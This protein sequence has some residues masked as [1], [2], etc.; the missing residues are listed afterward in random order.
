MITR[1]EQ[2][3]KQLDLANLDEAGEN[4]SFAAKIDAV[5]LHRVF[6]DSSCVL[7]FT[8]LRKRSTGVAKYFWFESLFAE[9]ILPVDSLCLDQL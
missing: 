2:S 7:A 5:G 9:V 8:E 6:N 3:Q 1:K 4:S